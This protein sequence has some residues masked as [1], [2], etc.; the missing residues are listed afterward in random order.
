M[1]AGT[2]PPTVALAQ[3]KVVG[4]ELAHVCNL[5]EV[6]DPIAVCIKQDEWCTPPKHDQAA[7][8]AHQSVQHYLQS[9]VTTLDPET[10]QPVLA[11]GEIIDEIMLCGDICMKGHLKNEKA[12]RGTSAG[13]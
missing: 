13:D 2:S 3:M 11:D 7:M 8:K 10:V 5:T 12:T 4:S 9:Q 1:V 6:C